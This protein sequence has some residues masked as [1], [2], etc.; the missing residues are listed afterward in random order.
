MSRRSGLLLAAVLLSAAL[1]CAGT[2]EQAAS[3]KL[4]AG[5]EIIPTTTVPATTEGAPPGGSI[6]EVQV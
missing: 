3:P 5:S 4:P 2:E 1:P 6:E